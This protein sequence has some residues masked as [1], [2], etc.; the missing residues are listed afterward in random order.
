MMG[1]FICQKCYLK[2][3]RETAVYDICW[4]CLSHDWMCAARA[5]EDQGLVRGA[6]GFSDR[7][8]K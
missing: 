1:I 2:S 3:Q 6:E 5:E 8:F 7:L 4:Q